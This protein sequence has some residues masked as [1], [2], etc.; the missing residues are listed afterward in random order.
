M[1]GFSKD[2]E[3]TRE[4]WIFMLSLLKAVASCGEE[5]LDVMLMHKRGDLAGP[6]CSLYFLYLCETFLPP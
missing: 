5:W 4:S 6:V 2:D 3:R 1:G